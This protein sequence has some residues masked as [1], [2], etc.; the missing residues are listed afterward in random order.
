MGRRLYQRKGIFV[1]FSM[2]RKKLDQDAK[3]SVVKLEMKEGERFDQLVER[4]NGKIQVERSG[5]KTAVDK[6]YS[7][8]NVLPRPILRLFSAVLPVLDYFNMMPRVLIDPDGLY[9]SLVIANLGSIGMAPG[10]HHLYE[11]G[12]TGGFMMVG[13]VEDRAVVE[14][15][16]IVPRRVLPI[17]FSYDERIDD[18]LSAR[19]AMDK[20][21]AILSDPAKFLGCVADDGSDKKPMV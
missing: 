16:K 18:G 4:I 21:A 11:W 12:N 20:M 14:D 10:Y 5:K 19:Q 1:T 2:K 8:F 6:E 13:K 9:T 7:L 3:L 17:R 15:G